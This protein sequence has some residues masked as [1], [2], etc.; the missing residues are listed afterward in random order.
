MRPS[1]Q[2]RE[3]ASFDELMAGSGLP[4]IE[5]RA[6]LEH[7]SGTSREWLIAHGDESAGSDLAESFAQ[8]AQRRREGEPLAYLVGEREFHGRRFE[9]GPAVL[10]PRPETELL[11]DLVA[12]AAC[13]GAGILELGTGSGCIAIS[14]ACLRSDL[15]IV[16]T[17]AS[18]PALALAARNAT[19]LCPEALAVTRLQFRLGNWWSAVLPNERFDLIVSNPPYIAAGDPHL[20]QGDLRFEPADALASG[21]NGLDALRTIC[22]GAP[23]RLRAGGML[24]LEHGFDQ[25]AAVRTLLGAAG[26]EQIG[27]LRDAAGLDR[28]T[29]GRLP[30]QEQ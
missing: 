22:S 21:E 7:A 1:N 11:V 9:V 2:L 15:S 13:A 20:A 28:V 12:Q 30:G 8:L 16:A 23:L 26:F 3:P 10:I 18:A 14:L 24:F 19:S 4:R 5:A 27:T 6:L 17:D 25:G 29:T